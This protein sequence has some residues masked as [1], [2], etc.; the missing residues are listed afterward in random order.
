MP[1]IHGI[2]GGRGTQTS[3]TPEGISPPPHTNF[4][5]AIVGWGEG[6]FGHLS[7][8]CNAGR[9]KNSTFD[10]VYCILPPSTHL[11]RRV[12]LQNKTTSLNDYLKSQ[13]KYGVGSPKFHWAPL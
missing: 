5:A 9:A 2:G 4:W 7:A 6:G 3:F 8:V 1:T 13:V 10:A 11:L 12:R